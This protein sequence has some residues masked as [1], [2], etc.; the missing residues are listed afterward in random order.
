MAVRAVLAAESYAEYV[1]FGGGAVLIALFTL[2]YRGL[3]A[4]ARGTNRLIQQLQDERDDAR[5][6]SEYNAEMARYWQA[7]FY[8]YDPGPP[9]VPPHPSAGP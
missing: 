6:W 8:G 1:G 5:R 4:G 2:A 7:R 3:N 9:P